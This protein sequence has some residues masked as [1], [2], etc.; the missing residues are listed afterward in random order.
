MD[1]CH[2]RIDGLVE[3]IQ[4]AHEYGLIAVKVERHGVALFPHLSLFNVYFP[5]PLPWEDG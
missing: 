2:F 3:S 1:I 5:P 4:F